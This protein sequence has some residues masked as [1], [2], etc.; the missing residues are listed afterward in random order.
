MGLDEKKKFN[1]E[2]NAIQLKFK[3]MKHTKGK[4]VFNALRNA[5]ESD[6]E[7]DTEPNIEDGEEGIPV[8]VIST[9]SAMGGK[10]TNADIKLICSAPELLET[11]IRLQ[12]VIEQT[13]LLTPTSAWRN[14]LCDENI[15]ALLLIESLNK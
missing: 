1:S 15:K 2:T 9:F 7:W 11:V 13:I 14:K 12:A 8:Q 5:I 10:D 3:T 4:W 6:S